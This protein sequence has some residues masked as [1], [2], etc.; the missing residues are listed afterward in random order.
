M[1]EQIGKV[2]GSIWRLLGEKGELNLTSIPKTIG[3]KGEVAYQALGWLAKE[4]K[5]DYTS[6]QGKVF[7]SL[8]PSEKGAFELLLQVHA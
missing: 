2:A 1:R 5:I 6:K 3:E 4:G 7:V 8:T